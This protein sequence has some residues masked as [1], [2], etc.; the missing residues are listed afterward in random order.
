MIVCNNNMCNSH[1]PMSN[2]KGLLLLHAIIPC[3]LY[4]VSM[5]L[6]TSIPTYPSTMFFTLVY[7]FSFA[8]SRH[9][10]D[11]VDGGTLLIFI[12]GLVTTFFLVSMFK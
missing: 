4:L 5:F 3:M 2:Y 10:H 7:L 8:E 1:I 9:F 11:H 12:G 6:V